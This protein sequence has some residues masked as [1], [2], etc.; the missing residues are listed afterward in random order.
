MKKYEVMLNG[1]NLLL[2]LGEG[3]GRYGFYTTCYVAAAN[4]R[5]A[6]LNAVAWIKSQHNFNTILRNEPKDPPI[7][8]AEDIIIMESPD[9]DEME[10]DITWFREN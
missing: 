10:S 6:E 1:Q 4:K 5:E 2:D 8:Y 3:M 7:F 9:A